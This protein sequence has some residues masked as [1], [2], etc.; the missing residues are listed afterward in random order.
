MICHY[1][2]TFFSPHVYL[3][4]QIEEVFYVGAVFETPVDSYVTRVSI[5]EKKKKKI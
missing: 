2:V 5:K 4:I 3:S 1:Y